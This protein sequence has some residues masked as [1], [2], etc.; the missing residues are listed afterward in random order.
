MEWMVTLSVAAK[1]YPWIDSVVRNVKP[2]QDSGMGFGERD[3]AWYYK[4]EGAARAF[5]LRLQLALQAVKVR[6]RIAVMEVE[7]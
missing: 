4:N 5:S 7:A 3:Y 2:L 6:G 1:H